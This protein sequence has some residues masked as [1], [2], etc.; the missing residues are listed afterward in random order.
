MPAHKK[1]LDEDRVAELAYE[2]ASNREIGD[3]LGC[4][5]KTVESR[6][7]PLLRKK[8][9]E[10]RMKLRKAQFDAAV[11]GNATMLVW[12]G[13]QELDQTDKVEQRTAP[14][15]LKVNIHR[16]DALTKPECRDQ[17]TLSNSNS[18]VPSDS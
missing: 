17:R 8:R 15:T 6:F 1:P 13:K 9:A 12:L 3:I 11:G 2:G 7:S 18:A 16:P 10:R 5:H 4:D 14:S